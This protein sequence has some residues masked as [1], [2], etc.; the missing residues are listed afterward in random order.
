VGYIALVL[1]FCTHLPYIVIVHGFDVLA[2]HDNPWKHFWLKVILKNARAVIANS[3]FTKKE[4]RRLGI[5]EK[6]VVAVYPCVD[7]RLMVLGMEAAF[8]APNRRK[9]LLTVGRLVARKGHDTVIRALPA[10]AAE[11]PDILYTIAG[12]GPLRERLE[13][14]AR[15]MGVA[16]RVSF[17][18][19]VAEPALSALYTASDIFVMPARQ[20]GADVEGFGLVFLEAN[21]F[22]KPVVGGRSGGVPEAVADG[23]TGILVP[24]DDPAALAE[25]VT[26]L[27]KNPDLATRLGAR[28]RE[29]AR[30][31]FRWEVQIQKIWPLFQ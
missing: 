19:G 17:L 27:L 12:D 8:A 20:I 28:G 30:E 18:G 24:P 7:K 6:S 10:I 13:R 15:E 31:E 25:V 5:P 22:G 1:R 9:T 21:A 16:E 23:E 11:F 26:R 3:E 29:R 4:V 14:L 2:P